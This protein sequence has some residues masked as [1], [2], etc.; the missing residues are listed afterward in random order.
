MVADRY[1]NLCGAEV[2][3]GQL[4]SRRHRRLGFE[5]G[6]RFVVNVIV[7]HETTAKPVED[8]P[9][10]ELDATHTR[11]Y[12]HTST[13]KLRHY[14][15]SNPSLPL[16]RSRDPLPV[17]PSSDDEIAPSKSGIYHTSILEEIQRDH[18]G[19]ADTFE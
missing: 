6:M 17:F 7:V 3:L 4:D 16:T 19:P 15:P 1:N 13:L 10:Q 8:S 9:L 18:R 2:T 5:S 14:A 11:Y 12:P